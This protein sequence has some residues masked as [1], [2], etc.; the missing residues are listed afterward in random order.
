VEK[1]QL[2]PTFPDKPLIKTYVAL[3]E[4]C[5]SIAPLQLSFLEIFNLVG[6]FWSYAIS[7]QAKWNKKRPERRRRRTASRACEPLRHASTPPFPGVRTSVSPLWTVVPRGALCR[8]DPCV[9]RAHARERVGPGHAPRVRAPTRRG[10]HAGPPPGHRVLVIPLLGSPSFP[11]FR[12]HK[13]ARERTLFAPPVR[14][15]PPLAGAAA[16]SC[17]RAEPSPP[18][19]LLPPYNSR[20]TPRPSPRRN[21]AAVAGKP[22]SGGRPP[23]LR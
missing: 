19:L 18:G 11:S 1:L 4:S 12:V 9:C 5:R 21:L 20:S 13:N 17:S 22:G 10:E 15:R 3:W 7:K 23:A 6:T 14:R 8:L 16:G 2:R